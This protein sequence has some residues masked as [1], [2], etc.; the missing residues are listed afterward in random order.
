MYDICN[1]KKSVRLH[2]VTK[3]SSIYARLRGV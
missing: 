1:C 3:K 2:W